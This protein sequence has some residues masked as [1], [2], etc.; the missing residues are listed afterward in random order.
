MRFANVLFYLPFTQSHNF[1]RIGVGQ[2]VAGGVKYIKIRYWRVIDVFWSWKRFTRPVQKT[3]DEDYAGHS[4]PHQHDDPE[5]HTKVIYQ[6]MGGSSGV[7]VKSQ[8][9][10]DENNDRNM[11]KYNHKNSNP[12]AT[13][14][15][16]LLNHSV[17]YILSFSINLFPLLLFSLLLTNPFLIWTFFLLNS[18]CR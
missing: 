12:A 18:F 1:I 10:R 4:S 2:E 16:L 14:L 17:W 15:K 3:V 8:T 9:G 11:K 5:R 6:L 13:F 7:A